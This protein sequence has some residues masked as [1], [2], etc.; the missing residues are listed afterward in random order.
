MRCVCDVMICLF[1][2]LGF[3]TIL[4]FVM[5]ELNKEKSLKN[6]KGVDAVNAFNLRKN[7]I[8]GV[9]FFWIPSHISHHKFFN[10]S[11]YF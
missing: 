3:I 9:L 8:L 2:F 6:S 4:W 10:Y 1:V 5:S 7:K 11:D